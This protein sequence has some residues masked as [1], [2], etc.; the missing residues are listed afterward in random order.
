[1]NKMAEVR[2]LYFS[3]GQEPVLKDINWES[4]EGILLFS[5]DPMVQE[6]A[7]C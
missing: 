5:L 3:Y 1:M 6:R 4:T 7:P 2:N